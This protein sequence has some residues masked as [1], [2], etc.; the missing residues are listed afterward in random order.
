MIIRKQKQQT[1][2]HCASK[3]TQQKKGKLKDLHKKNTF[4]QK[5]TYCTKQNATTLTAGLEPATTHH[6]CCSTIELSEFYF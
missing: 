3:T 4:K 2:A 5:K 6:V 1:S